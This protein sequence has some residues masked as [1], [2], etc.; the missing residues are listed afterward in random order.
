MRGRKDNLIGLRKT[1]CKLRT[2]YEGGG[3]GALGAL[4]LAE[5]WGQPPPRR[6]GEILLA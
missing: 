6:S 1:L 2:G 5:G 4:A 3:H